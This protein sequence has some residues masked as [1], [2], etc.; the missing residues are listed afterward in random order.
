MKRFRWLGVGGL[1][2]FTGLA[3]AGGWMLAKE[4]EPLQIGLSIGSRAPD[5]ALIDQRGNVANLPPLL[6]RGKLALV[7]FR[8]ADW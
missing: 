5:F 2:A 6:T 1:V 3:V 4:L 8:S 7:F